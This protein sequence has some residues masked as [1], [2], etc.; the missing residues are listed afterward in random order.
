MSPFNPSSGDTDASREAAKP[1]Q[2]LGKDLLLDDTWLEGVPGRVP[3][4]VPGEGG[5]EGVCG[6]GTGRTDGAKRR[7]GSAEEGKHHMGGVGEQGK[8]VTLFAVLFSWPEAIKYV[9]HY[10]G[11]HCFLALDCIAV[12]FLPR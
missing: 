4:R 11:F 5:R 2:S 7:A 12:C 9:P 3:G 10:P 6:E 8:R 1:A